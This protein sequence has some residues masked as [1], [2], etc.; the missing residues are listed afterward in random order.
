MTRKLRVVSFLAVMT[1][2]AATWGISYLGFELW[3]PS[4][5]LADGRS[6]PLKSAEVE[7]CARARGLTWLGDRNGDLYWRA[8][9]DDLS[10]YQSSAGFGASVLERH[11]HR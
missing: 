8:C 6:I 10:R 5:A 9:R 4:A 3:P 1:C 7:A 11:R 2:F